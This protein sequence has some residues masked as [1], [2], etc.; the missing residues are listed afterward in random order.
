MSSPI[1]LITW[2]I[3]NVC[4]RLINSGYPRPQ[5]APTL[6]STS[7][8]TA[9]AWKLLQLWGPSA[10]TGQ[11][12]CC[13][14]CQPPPTCHSQSPGQG[15]LSLWGT[16]VR[17]PRQELGADEA[18]GPWAGGTADSCLRPNT[19]PRETWIFWGRLQTMALQTGHG[20]RPF[21]PRHLMA[22]GSLKE[23]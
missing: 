23:N 11:P 5:R 20:P 1:P 17:N 10:L 19:Q 4:H 18:D 16:Q 22:A 7:S 2:S 15:G 3:K 6:P 8:P 21:L 12:P 9:D 13:R 14:V